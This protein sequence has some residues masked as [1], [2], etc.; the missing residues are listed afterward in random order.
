MNNHPQCRCS[1]FTS[2]NI[3]CLS[4]FN[5]L[6][7]VITII[8]CTVLTCRLNTN[9]TTINI[10]IRGLVNIMCNR[11]VQLLLIGATVEVI[12]NFIKVA[13]YA[14]EEDC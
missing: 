7:I 5:L 3:W 9:V 14:E 11:L 12:L 8:H 13:K 4:L 2:S 1:I 6:C 10:V